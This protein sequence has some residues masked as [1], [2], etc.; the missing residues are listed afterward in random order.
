MWEYVRLENR[1]YPIASQTGT[2]TKIYTA[3]GCT[4]KN[5]TVSLSHI[6]ISMYSIV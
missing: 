3:Y 4:P 5:I 6:H 2:D 1:D